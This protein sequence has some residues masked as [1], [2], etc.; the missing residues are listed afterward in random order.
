MR[1]FWGTLLGIS[2]ALTLIILLCVILIGAVLSRFTPQGEDVS[3]RQHFHS[4]SKGALD[5][6]AVVH[7]DGVIL[8]G[9]TGY[10]QKQIEEAGR[11]DAVK[12]VVIRINSP[13]GSITASDDLYHRI[14]ELRDGVAGK[15]PAKPLVVSMASLAASGGYYIAVP[16]RHIIAER[17]TITGSIGVYA[18]FLNMAELADNYGVKME[19]VKRGDLKAG[20]SMLQ[21][22]TPQE[23][24]LWQDMVDHAYDTFLAV[25]RDG[26]GNKL[27]YGLQAVIKEET[28]KIAGKKDGNDVPVEYVRRLA[29]GGI[30]TSDKAR[31]YG[32]IDDI[33][34]LDDAVAAAANM[35]SLGERYKAITYERPLSLVTLLLG[36]KAAPPGNQ[37]DWNHL[38]A[39]AVPRL[40]Y[41]AP[42]TTLSGFLAASGTTNSGE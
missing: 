35:A 17:T 2:L 7:I 23:R 28:K 36:A 6:I 5:K 13:G 37:L 11:D 16:A 29:D 18:A 30:F 8:E 34:Y 38:A 24:Q 14:V 33:G 39:G 4:G 1:W 21:E 31:Q 26:R 12:A 10:A 22:M 41:L 40:W 42:Q 20:G 32:L 3:L 19:I 9:L 25:V 15:R 27:K